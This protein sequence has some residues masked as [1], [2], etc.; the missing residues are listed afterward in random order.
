MMKRIS[1]RLAESRKPQKGTC[2]MDTLERRL[3][4]LERDVRHCRSITLLLVV[5]LT[6][7]L[8]LGATTDTGL[9]EGT[10]L[11]LLDSDGNVLVQAGSV[12]GGG[13]LAIFSSAGSQVL[14]AGSSLQSNGLLK[15]NSKAG[16]D[17]VIAGVDQAGNG[18]VRVLSSAGSEIV[19]AGPDVSGNGMLRIRSAANSDLVNIGAG[20]SGNGFGLFGYNKTGQIVVIMGAG[21]DG[22]GLVGAYDRRGNGKTLQPGR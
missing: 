9:I 11:R 3:S 20:T 4:R 22:R 17:A 15:V 13:G 6:A 19:F 1:M 12:E 16:T 10:E 5:T 7:V 2:K 21:E 8:S 18:G 14:F